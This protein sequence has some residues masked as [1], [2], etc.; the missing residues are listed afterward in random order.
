MF[1]MKVNMITLQLLILNYKIWPFPTQRSKD[2]KDI[3]DPIGQ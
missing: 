1:S 2:K 3:F